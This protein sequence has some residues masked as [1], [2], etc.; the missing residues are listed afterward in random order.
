MWFMGFFVTSLHIFLIFVNGTPLTRK[1][2][3]TQNVQLKLGG[4]G[5][6][7]VVA[8][9]EGASCNVNVPDV[10]QPYGEPGRYSYK[11]NFMI[12]R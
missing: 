5:D 11:I 7:S 9:K 1:N 4:K 3:G 10:P 12:N 6:P 2:V 8:T